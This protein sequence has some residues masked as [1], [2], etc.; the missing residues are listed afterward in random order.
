M[1]RQSHEAM[2]ATQVPRE[3]IQQV[4]EQLAVQQQHF[5]STKVHTP[6]T[7][8]K[9]SRAE[10]TNGKIGGVRNAEEILEDGEFVD[11]NTE[12]CIEASEDMYSEC[13][14]V[15]HELRSVDDREER[16]GT[17]WS[18]S[19]GKTPRKNYSIRTLGNRFRVQRECMYPRP[20]KDVSQV[21]LAILQREENRKATMSALGGDV[22]IP[23]L[24]RMSALLELCRKEL[25]TMRLDEIGENLENLKAKVVS[26]PTNKTEQTRG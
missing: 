21:R 7:T 23:D 20:A 1:L 16:D 4:F 6:Q 26:Y 22:K 14:G 9:R 18:R 19:L 2:E 25:M 17:G 8:G 11:A 15:V 13:V 12:G 24:W 5:I 10:K 3:S